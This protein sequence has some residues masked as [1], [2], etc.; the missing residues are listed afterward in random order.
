VEVVVLAV[1]VWLEGSDDPEALVEATRQLRQ[2][3]AEADIGD[4]RPG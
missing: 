2:E 4:V 1:R 3:L